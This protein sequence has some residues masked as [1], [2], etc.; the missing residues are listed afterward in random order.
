MACERALG[1][2]WAETLRLNTAL[3]ALSL[4]CNHLDDGAWL[5]LAETV[6]LNTTLTTLDLRINGLGEGE[7]AGE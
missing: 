7:G 3:T 6:R 4:C 2:H 5:V 1:R